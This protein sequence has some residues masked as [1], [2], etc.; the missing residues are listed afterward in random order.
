M[1]TILAYHTVADYDGI[2]PAGINTPIEVFRSHMDYLFRHDYRVV[3]LDQ[4]VDHIINGKKMHGKALAITFDDGYEDHFINVYPILERYG[5]PATIFL[6][7]KYINGY[8][9][10]EKVKGG[11]I[12]ALTKEQIL[13]MKKGELIEFGSHGYSHSNLLTISEEER[14]FEIRDSKSYL[15]KLLDEDVFFI[16]YPFGACNPAIEKVVK[17]AGYKA[18]FSIWNRRFNPYCISRTPLHTRDGLRRFRFK[19]SS[20][21][22]PIKSVFRFA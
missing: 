18:G 15:E 10:S 19:I 2:L 4:I 7:V 5:F 11:G 21:F 13:E 16:S 1:Y 20:L 3:R 6:T 17:E 12:K 14:F 8:W 22:I 9:E